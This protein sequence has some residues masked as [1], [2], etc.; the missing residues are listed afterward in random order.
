[1]RIFNEY[2]RDIPPT[3]LPGDMDD[4]AL[5]SKL[6]GYRECHL[7]PDVILVYT[8]EKDVVHLLTICNHADIEG[9]RQ[10]NTRKRLEAE[11]AKPAPLRD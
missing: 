1:M 7:A 2:K 11:Q 4:H 5:R 3:P 10:E 9:K 8:H 6:A